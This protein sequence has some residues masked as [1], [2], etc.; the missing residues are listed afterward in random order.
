MYNKDRDINTDPHQF[1]LVLFCKERINDKVIVM[2]GVEKQD[3][4]L[5]LVKI[6][7][8]VA[9]SGS[10]EEELSDH[11]DKQRAAQEKLSALSAPSHGIE[12]ELFAIGSMS[13]QWTRPAF[14]HD[15]R[16]IIVYCHGGGYI[17]GGLGYAS[18]LAGKMA[19]TTG[20]P[21]LSFEYR[22]APEHPYPAAIEDGMQVW[23]Y[24]MQMGYGADHVILAGDSAGGNMALEI[25]M[26]LKRQKRFLPAGL[27]LMSPWTD[28]TAT[29]KS[30]EKYKE[31]DP[32]LSREYVEYARKAYAGERE[33]YSAPQLSP[34]YGDLTEFPPVKIQVGSCEILRL[35]S[36]LLYKKLQQ[37]HVDTEI[38]VY[39]GLWHVFQQTPINRSQQAMEEINRFIR[40]KVWKN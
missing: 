4:L 31:Q 29:T 6:L 7:H 14:P 13:A 21:V 28:M 22:L 3:R 40:L 9:R 19:L 1:C 16:H 12:H 24:V 2:A 38:S 36:E 39:K 26:E 15:Y 23:D 5:K 33:D 37:N 10:T 35:D 32:I 27:I 17:C 20:Y 8:S 11:L 25:V 18:I 34:L 30:Y